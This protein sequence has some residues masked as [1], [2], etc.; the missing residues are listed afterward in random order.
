MRGTE[1]YKHRKQN[2]KT[3]K[4][5]YRYKAKYNGLELDIFEQT[6]G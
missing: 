1:K 4:Y 6:S 2:R 5:K 3:E